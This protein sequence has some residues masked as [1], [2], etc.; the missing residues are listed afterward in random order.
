MGEFFGK[1]DLLLHWDEMS[2]QSW[3]K[4]MQ[5]KCHRL[6]DKILQGHTV[7]NR[8]NLLG[9]NVTILGGQTIRPPWDGMSQ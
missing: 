4:N 6:W 2:Q 8:P 9:R 3:T 1:M 5:T 7:T